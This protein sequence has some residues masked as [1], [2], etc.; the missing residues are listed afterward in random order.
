MRSTFYIGTIRRSV[1]NLPVESELLI[2]SAFQCFVREKIIEPTKIQRHTE[3]SG[4][5][6]IFEQIDHSHFKHSVQPRIKQ[7]L[8]VWSDWL[9]IRIDN[10]IIQL[11]DKV[12]REEGDIVKTWSI[13][14]K[15]FCKFRL[16]SYRNFHFYI[17]CLEGLWGK[18]I[19]KK[20]IIPLCL[21]RF[22][23]G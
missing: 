15:R 17:F 23:N 22:C 19:H 21:R 4:D 9:V 11:R 13:Q 16:F 3:S 6:I 5:P 14:L 18:L 12:I 2:K 1:S 20:V 10:R 8:P 7:I